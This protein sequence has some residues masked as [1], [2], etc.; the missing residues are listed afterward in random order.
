MTTTDSAKE[1]WE[2]CPR[3]SRRFVHAAV[4]ATIAVALML[5]C[6]AVADEHRGTSV[7]HGH[8]DAGVKARLEGDLRLAL[9]LLRKAWALEQSALIAAKLAQTELELGYYRDAI[10]HFEFYLQRPEPSPEDRAAVARLLAEAKSKIV[11][12]DIRVDAPGAEILLDGAVVGVAPLLREMPVDPGRRLVEARKAGCTF[13]RVSAEFAPGS[14]QNLSFTC[15]KAVPPAPKDNG[16]WSTWDTAAVVSGGIGV[17]GL[18]AGLIWG[19]GDMMNSSRLSDDAMQRGTALMPRTPSTMRVCG[20]DSPSENASECAAIASKLEASDQA[21][22]DSKRGYLLAGAG[23][24]VGVGAIIMAVVPTSAN[25]Q[26]SV[27][28][29]V[30]RS[31]SGVVVTMSF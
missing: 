22:N 3:R 18:G 5:S 13:E 11:V 10:E 8:Y 1:A 20:P 12:L 9:D 6:N 23:V 17:V 29:V 2:R 19:I 21:W 25:K 31:E 24:L 15:K 27:V 4:I 28:P 16:K 14:R 30:K 7:A 26:V